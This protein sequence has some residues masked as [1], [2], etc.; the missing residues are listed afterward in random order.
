MQQTLEPYLAEHPFLKGMN[1]H[2]VELITGCAENRR[3]N[4]GEFLY[5]EGDEATH[6]YFIRHGRLAQE[7]LRPQKGGIV[8][9]TSGPGDVL[10]WAWLFPPHFRNLDCRAVELTRVLALDGV[11]LREKCEQDHE[12]GYEIMKRFAHLMEQ[13]LESMRLRLLDIYGNND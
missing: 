11:C 9:Q 8:I 1:S 3:Y 5:R 6:F 4:P 7:I 10:G 2:H 13:E 12:L